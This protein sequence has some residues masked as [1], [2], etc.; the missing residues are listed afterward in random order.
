MFRLLRSSL[1]LVLLGMLCCCLDSSAG[2]SGPTKNTR[3]CPT[4]P[5]PEND[6]E[7]AF[8]NLCLTLALLTNAVIIGSATNLLSTM[9]AGAMAKKTQLDEINGYMRFRKV[10]G[11]ACLSPGAVGGR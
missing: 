3:G 6:A 9:D 8:S 4:I 1:R 5:E 2:Y 10:G 7:Y 11:N